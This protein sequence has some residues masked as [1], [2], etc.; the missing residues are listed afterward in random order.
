MKNNEK[1]WPQHKYSEVSRSEGNTNILS[2]VFTKPFEMLILP[3]EEG[4]PLSPNQYGFRNKNSVGHGITLLNDLMCYT[5][6]HIQ[7]KKLKASY[8]A[9]YFHGELA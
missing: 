1:Q 9:N 2:S 6:D 8:L 3:D 5:K 4:L 7:M